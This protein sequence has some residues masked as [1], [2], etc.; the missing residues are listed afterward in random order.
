MNPGENR[1]LRRSDQ[2]S[3]TIAYDKTFRRVGASDMPTEKNARENF[4]F[5]GCG[6]PQHMLLPKGTPEGMQ[7]DLF[8]MISNYSNDLVD[9]PYDE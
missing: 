7:F 3:V 4:Q 5:C 1:I 9:Q 6:W 8:V 2:S